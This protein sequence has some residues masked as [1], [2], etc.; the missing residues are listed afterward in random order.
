MKVLVSFLLLC[1]RISKTYQNYSELKLLI[2]AESL[3]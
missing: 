2:S 3:Q 1:G